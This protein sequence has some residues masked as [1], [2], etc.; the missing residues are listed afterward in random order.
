M[1]Y[2]QDK[3]QPRSPAATYES[4]L[5]L[6]EIVRSPGFSEHT[7]L[8]PWVGTPE[9]QLGCTTAGLLFDLSRQQQRLV[10]P[11]GALTLSYSLCFPGYLEPSAPPPAQDEHLTPLP[12]RTLAVR[13][14][15]TSLFF[16]LCSSG[17]PHLLALSKQPG[18]RFAVDSVLGA[19]LPAGG[20]RDAPA[21]EHKAM[22]ER[23]SAVTR[24]SRPNMAARL[25]ASLQTPGTPIIN[26]LTG[27]CD[28]VRLD[29]LPRLK[30]HRAFTCARTKP[31][32]EDLVRA[33]RAGGNE[34]EKAAR[35]LRAMRRAEDG[36]VSQRRGYVTRAQ[37][38]EVLQ[39]CDYDERVARLLLDSQRQVSRV[40][41]DILAQSGLESGI[42]WP[43]RPDVEARLAMAGNDEVSVLSALIQENRASVEMMA[44]IITSDTIDRFLAPERASLY[45]LS[46][47]PTTEERRRVEALYDEFGR[48]EENLHHF[49]F[50]VGQIVCSLD[51]LTTPAWR[52]LRELDGPALQPSETKLRPRAALRPSRCELEGYVREFGGDLAKAFLRANRCLTDAARK[53]GS[54]DRA[55]IARYVR[56]AE[57]NEQEAHAFALAVWKLVNTKP[58]KAV[59]SKTPAPPARGRSKGGN[60]AKAPV[61]LAEKCGFPSRAEAEAALLAVKAGKDRLASAVAMLERVDV[62]HRFISPTFPA[63]RWL[64]GVGTVLARKE[65]FGVDSTEEESTACQPFA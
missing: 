6:L 43:T 45:G 10:T 28:A 21:S 11:F 25:T 38:R 59:K 34:V 4:L 57:C 2:R 65:H 49:L 14:E 12:G 37:V 33:M 42:G 53:L 29:L 56:A 13:P 41:D 1:Q 7:G 31:S 5:G 26:E 62:L 44:E 18:P 46:S 47:P 8:Q 60:E 63:K 50:A 40:A 36:L 35:H 3:G 30:Q 48:S 52:P 58:P 22:R 64:C 19:P 24:A 23:W 20:L 15:R 54:P 17:A 9:P 27:R 32:E 61:T 51:N 16:A 55:T 39:T